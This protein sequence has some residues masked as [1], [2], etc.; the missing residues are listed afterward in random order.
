MPTRKPPPLPTRLP[1]LP[2]FPT[3]PPTPIQGTNYPS[4]MLVKFWAWSSEESRAYLL[5]LA[6]MFAT[7]NGFVAGAQAV[8][9]RREYK[10][11]MLV[12]YYNAC[13]EVDRAY[14][15]RRAETFAAL[16]AKERP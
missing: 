7:H 11:A 3:E 10:A 4:A 6:E 5:T 1:P 13:D 16:N 8:P 9:Q 14:L 12:K 2:S 15:L